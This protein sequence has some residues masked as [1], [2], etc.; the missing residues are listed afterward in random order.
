MAVQKWSGRQSQCDYSSIFKISM[1]IRIT[2][3]HTGNHIHW[4]ALHIWGSR[5]GCW[6]AL[7]PL[8]P[9]LSLPYQQHNLL[10]LPSPINTAQPYKPYQHSPALQAPRAPQV[11]QSHD[12]LPLL[13]SFCKTFLQYLVSVNSGTKLIKYKKSS[14]QYLATSIHPAEAVPSHHHLFL[15]S[16]C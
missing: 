6:L 12:C 5:Q 3:T 13:E 1:N 8:P 11:A 4:L 7:A 2:F 10:S 15:E 14:S 9:T 16:P